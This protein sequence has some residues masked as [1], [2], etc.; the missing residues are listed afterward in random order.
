M[1]RATPLKPAATGN[2]SAPPGQ[3]VSRSGVSEGESNGESSDDSFGGGSLADCLQQLELL[4]ERAQ[5]QFGLEVA[6]FAYEDGNSDPII[7][8]N[9]TA[10]AKAGRSETINRGRKSV[11]LSSKTRKPT[12]RK[13]RVQTPTRPSGNEVGGGNSESRAGSV[14]SLSS[15]SGAHVRK[16]SAAE[17]IHGFDEEIVET[18]WAGNEQSMK[19]FA[20]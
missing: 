11:D 2:E 4:V 3:R 13:A 16:E 7:L 8:G 1:P 9:P 18:P 6:V 14:A 17:S 15:E 20:I 12:V 5:E 10:I 19:P